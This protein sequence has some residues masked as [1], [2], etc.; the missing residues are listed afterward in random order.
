MIF[1]IFHIVG[2]RSQVERFQ[3]SFVT[4]SSAVSSRFGKGNMHGTDCLNCAHTSYAWQKQSVTLW[5][6]K[7]VHW[8]AVMLMHFFGGI[9]RPL[10]LEVCK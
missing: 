7:S 4:S 2:C 10:I 1:R 5:Q 3:G 8:T 9:Y 6:G